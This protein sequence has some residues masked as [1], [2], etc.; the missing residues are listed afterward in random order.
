MV[1]EIVR[2]ERFLSLPSRDAT[3]DDAPLFRDL[4]DTFRTKM[5]VCAGMAAN[6]IGERKN[7]IIVA[8]GP[9]PVVMVNPTVVKKS[10]EYVTK[11]G[12]LSLDGEREC[13]RYHEIEVEY[14]D[15]SFRKRMGKFSGF[16]AEVIQ[17]EMDHLRGIVI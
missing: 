14:L 4:E 17:H 9:M 10:G 3:E 11:E 6:M 16:L 7:I 12:C 15:S 5:D 8:F 2:D 13:I 1:R